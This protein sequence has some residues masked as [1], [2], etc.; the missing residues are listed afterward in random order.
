MLD[1]IGLA[2]NAGLCIEQVMPKLGASEV[3]A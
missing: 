3:Q 1:D 2:D